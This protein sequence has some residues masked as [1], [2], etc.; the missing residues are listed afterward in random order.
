MVCL[1]KMFFL[2]LCAA[3]QK[4]EDP[5]LAKKKMPFGSNRRESS[6]CEG[7]IVK[8]LLLLSFYIV[9][10]FLQYGIEYPSQNTPASVRHL[11]LT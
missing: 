4:E 11:N 8:F 2:Q 5:G 7:E 10:F 6:K 9:F 1:I 3:A